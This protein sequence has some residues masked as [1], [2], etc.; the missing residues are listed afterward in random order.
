MRT[1][2][3]YEKEMLLNGNTYS[4]AHLALQWHEDICKEAEFTFA[5]AVNRYRARIDFNDGIYT[6][7]GKNGVKY[8]FDCEMNFRGAKF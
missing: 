8:F 4:F 5:D 3:G 7:W 2:K 6:L 1:L